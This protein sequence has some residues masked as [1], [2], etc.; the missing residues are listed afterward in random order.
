M[1]RTGGS[2]HGQF[3]ATKMFLF[4][5][6][7]DIYSC[8]DRLQTLQLGWLWC[9]NITPMI[10]VTWLTT[11]PWWIDVGTFK[12]KHESIQ[13]VFTSE[14]RAAQLRCL[15]M[16]WKL[17]QV[18]FSEQPTHSGSM[19]YCRHYTTVESTI[20]SRYLNKYP[21]GKRSTSFSVAISRMA[22]AFVSD[23]SVFKDVESIS[24]L[25]KLLLTK[26]KSKLFHHV[27]HEWRTHWLRMRGY[28]R[29]NTHAWTFW[30]PRQQITKPNL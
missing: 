24:R 3:Q 14:N 4:D 7:F 27:T 23:L 21:L 13:E 19:I 2:V 17:S 5:F 9:W 12:V 1:A 11:W 16:R 20:N 26:V 30:R 28:F 22:C 8:A 18:H 10:L 6:Y 15:K 29:D 25:L